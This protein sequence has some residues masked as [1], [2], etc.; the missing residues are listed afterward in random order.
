[1]RVAVFHDTFEHGHPVAPFLRAFADHGVELVHVPGADFSAADPTPFGAVVVFVRF[2]RLQAAPPIDWKGLTG[3]R[4]L[5]EHDASQNYARMASGSRY[6]GAW[7]REFERHG[8]DLMIASGR[9]VARRLEQDGVPTVWVPK[10]YDEQAFHELGLERAGICHFGKRYPARAAMLRHV[11]RGG[12]DVAHVAAP[13][14]ELNAALNRYAACL[15]CNMDGTPALGPV[16]RAL[17]LVAPGALVRAR[18]ALEPMIKNFE[19]AAAGCAPFVDAIP[20]LADLGFVDGETA[21]VYSTF[22]E[23][24]E[25]LHATPPGDLLDVGRRAARLAR[26]RHTWSHRVSEVLAAIGGPRPA[27]APSSTA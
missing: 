7:P 19:V 8:F 6:I 3:K 25:R 26:A 18:P 21:F 10:G 22:D 11:R 20:E 4:V 16:G 24:V 2:R 17:Q 23:L 13:Y 9:D 27:A 14:D 5:L 12:I 15:V 1:M